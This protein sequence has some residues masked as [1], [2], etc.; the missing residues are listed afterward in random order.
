MYKND[1]IVIGNANFFC[2]YSFIGN[3][4]MVIY[5]TCITNNLI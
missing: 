2:D 5:I 4:T 1:V 3:N